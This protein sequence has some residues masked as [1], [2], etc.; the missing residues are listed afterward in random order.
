MTHPEPTPRRQPIVE[1]ELPLGLDGAVETT[2]DQ[3]EGLRA[4]DRLMFALCAGLLALS[5]YA[6]YTDHPDAEKLVALFVLLTAG[7]FLPEK[8]RRR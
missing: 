8:W 2:R 4:R 7:Y 5:A 1:N 3:N 6:V